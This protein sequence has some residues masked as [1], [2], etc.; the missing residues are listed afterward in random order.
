ML[1]NRLIF[2]TL[3]TVFLTGFVLLDARLDG[4][5]GHAIQKGNVYGTG[6]VV[7]VALI[8]IAAQ[9]ELSKLASKRNIRIFLPITIPVT[10]LL[11]SSWYIR[12]C[13]DIDFL[14]YFF[15]VSAFSFFGIL[16]Y[17]YFCCLTQGVIANCGS[18]L[19]SIVYLGILAA[20]ITGIRVRFGPWHLLMVV[21]VVKT[22]DIGAYAIGKL[23]GRHKF[24]PIISPGKTWEGM[25]GAVAAA[26]LTAILF[27]RTFVIMS[28]FKAF[29]FGLCF[30][31]IGQMGDL[32]ESLIKR[33]AEQKDS[34]EAGDIGI[35]G[36]GGVLDVIDS[37]LGAGVFAY[38]FF[39]YVG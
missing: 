2:G 22:A 18:S 37:P 11:A 39:A 15:M 9:F 32:A 33:D 34:V 38:L 8:L 28:I 31:F 7:L 14:T 13:L 29:I 17:Q 25:A 20:F 19:F 24:S 3:M 30:A 26:V 36:F 27:S 10:I 12:Q 1:K 23:F 6:F 21:F 4:S 16:L 5:I 35:P